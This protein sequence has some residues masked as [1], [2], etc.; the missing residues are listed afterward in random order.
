MGKSIRGEMLELNTC[1]I[2]FLMYI[3]VCSCDNV[4]PIPSAHVCSSAI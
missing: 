3:K 1:L 2:V 4:F